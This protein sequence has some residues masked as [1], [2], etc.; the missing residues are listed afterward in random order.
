[1]ITIAD[2]ETDFANACVAA[3]RSTAAAAIAARGRFH[4][5][6]TGGTS[7]RPF[8]R[9]L[10]AADG[11]DWPSVEIW[12]GDERAVGP[13]DPKSNFGAAQADLLAHVPIPRAQIHRM[14]GEAGDLDAVAKGY[15]RA[16]V[17]R[18]D[19]A[20]DL[21]IV[22]IGK[23]AHILSLWPGSDLV[24]ERSSLVV[25]AIDPPMDPA[26]SRVTFT[27]AVVERARSVLA[28]VTGRDK[29]DAVTRARHA[30]DDPRAI[31]AHVLRRARSVHWIVDRDAFDPSAS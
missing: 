13:S 23:D 17:E 5:A 2:H 8:H 16:L 4:V 12:F 10:V 15:E 26:L 31:P 30:P 22:G 11:I 27:P 21:L 7:P 1:M 9:A 6:L 29:R 14:E 20:L 3:F 18:C 28:I 19:G 25:A 24:E